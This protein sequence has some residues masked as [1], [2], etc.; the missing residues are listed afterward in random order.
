MDDLFGVPQT[1]AQATDGGD[2]DGL[3]AISEPAAIPMK[4]AP[5]ASVFAEQQPLGIPL[6]P[7]SEDSPLR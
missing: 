7:L 1:A 2:D 6:A 3:T 5:A 4:A